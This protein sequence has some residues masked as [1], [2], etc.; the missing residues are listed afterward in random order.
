MEHN[1]HT[2]DQTNRAPDP[3][4]HPQPLPEKITSQDG[5]NQHAQRAQRRDQDRGREGVRAEVADLAHDHRDDARPPGGV[6]EVGEAV[7]FEAVGGGGCVEAFL[8]DDE[9]GPDADCAGHGEREA[10]VFVFY[11]GGGRAGGVCGD[12]CAS[13]TV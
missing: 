3:S 4:Q 1:D 10:N 8:G 5:P 2:P 6:L 7:A 11:H 13:G 12:G 9:G